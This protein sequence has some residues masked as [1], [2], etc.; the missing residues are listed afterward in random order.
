MASTCAQDDVIEGLLRQFGLFG[1]LPSSDLTR[2]ARAAAFRSMER[3]EVV[4]DY[5]DSVSGVYCVLS[6][7]VKLLVRSGRRK[8]R[9]FELAGSGHTFGEGLVFSDQPSP[10]RAV[11]IDD[12]RLLTVPAHALADLLER[13]PGFALRMLRRV[14]QRIGRLLTELESDTAQS[15][16]QR[17][18]GWLVAQIDPAAAEPR[19]RLEVSKATLAA[20]LNTTPE[21]FSR[22]LQHLRRQGVVRVGRR[23]I[24]VLS[25][26]RLRLLKPCVFCSK[27]LPESAGVPAL[28]WADDDAAPPWRAE[29][30]VPHWFG[31]CDCDVPHWCARA[32]QS[33]A[34]LTESSAGNGP[35][36]R[37]GRMA[38]RVR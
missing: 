17:I 2:L 29:S 26:A 3:G 7:M 25:P 31:Y 28:F 16:A 19:I 36:C 9:I 14:S 1:G 34:A 13:S 10:G 6:G 5:G 20:L 12:G 27:P 4:I 37:G 24:V 23:E 22:V 8:E 18:V 38:A 35:P 32:A 11:A 30:E 15:S 33:L 21:T